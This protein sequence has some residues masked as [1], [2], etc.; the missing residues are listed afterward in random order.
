MGQPERALVQLRLAAETGL[1]NYPLFL[2]D[3]HFDSLRARPDFREFLA[4][5][6]PGWEAYRREFGRGGGL[7]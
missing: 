4:G 3:R 2:G 7:P 5:L 1:P 6:K